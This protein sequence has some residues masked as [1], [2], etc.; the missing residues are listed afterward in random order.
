MY[1]TGLEPHGTV[2]YTVKLAPVYNKPVKNNIK[3]A[4]T[5]Y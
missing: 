2:M 3:L 4:V 1:I 5:I